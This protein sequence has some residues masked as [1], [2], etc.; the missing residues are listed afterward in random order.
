MEVSSWH[1]H[2]REK[3]EYFLV[4]GFEKT[5]IGLSVDTSLGIVIF[6]TADHQVGLQGSGAIY[7]VI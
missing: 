6:V 5:L 1:H 7:L 2:L 4:E 3:S